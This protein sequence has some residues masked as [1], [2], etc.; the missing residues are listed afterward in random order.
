[1]LYVIIILLSFL[2]VSNIPLMSLKF[3]DFSFKNNLPKYLLLII[4]IVAAIFLQWMLF[5]YY[6]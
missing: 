4:A 1:M 2:M 6:W 5:R 3:K